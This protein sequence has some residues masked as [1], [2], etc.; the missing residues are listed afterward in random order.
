LDAAASTTPATLSKSRHSVLPSTM[1]SKSAE[2]FYRSVWGVENLE[3]R[4]TSS[5][6]LLRFSYRV[7]DANRARLLNDKKAIPYLIDQKTG[8]VLQ[9]PTM[10]KVGMLRQSSD[11][12]NGLSYWMVF[13]NKGNFV[14]PG[15]RVDV[16]I[17]NFRAQ[18][19]VVQ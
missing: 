5:G 16:V 19:L 6:V 12:V 18:G 4:E 8:A 13:S 9:V 2:K 3:V 1:P 14:K 10:P 17:G 15:S 11:P 7:T